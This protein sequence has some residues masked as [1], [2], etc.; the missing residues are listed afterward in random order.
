MFE[1][2]LF[3]LFCNM[4]KKIKS[5]KILK[6]IGKEKKEK[7]YA[8]GLLQQEIHLYRFITLMEIK[9][10]VIAANFL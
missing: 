6:Q 8:L 7:S 5:K 9:E 1:L 3:T 10:Q 4:F 2:T